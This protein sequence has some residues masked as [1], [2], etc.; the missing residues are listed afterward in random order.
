[1]WNMIGGQDCSLNGVNATDTMDYSPLWASFIEPRE[2]NYITERVSEVTERSSL[3]PLLYVWQWRAGIWT[4]LSVFAFAT[5]VVLKKNKKYSILFVVLLAHILSLLLTTG[6]SD[7]RYYWP[8]VL[9]GLFLALI[10]WL[11]KENES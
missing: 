10:A 3:L 11:V 9:I 1:M 2:N 6:W 7:Y 8:I 4:L 5:V